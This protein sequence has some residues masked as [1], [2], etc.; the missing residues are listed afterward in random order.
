[1]L[2]VLVLFGS[3]HAQAQLYQKDKSYRLTILHTN[4]HHGRFWKNDNG[5]YGMAAR[6]TLIDRIRAEVKQ[7][8]G[9]LLLL[10]GGDIN[11]GVPQSD[12]L[13]AEPDFKG[14]KLLGYNAMSLGNHEFDQ[15]PDVLEQ[16][17]KWAGFPFLSANIFKTGTSEHA[18]QSYQVF[19]LDGL[20]VVV[21]G[22]TTKDTTLIANPANTGHLHFRPA[23]EVAK[24]LM[25]NLRRQ[26]AI[27]IAV[28]HL[29]HYA[30]G[31]HGGNIPG[32]VTLARSV[33]GFDVIVGGHT[34][35]PLPLP[36]R[37]NDTLILQAHEWG[38]YVGRL[39]LEFFNG[40]LTM[41]NY[42]LIPVN[43][44]QRL[45]GDAQADYSFIDKEIIEDQT[46]LDLLKPY[47][48]KGK[49]Q[50]SLVIG[51]VDT[52]FNGDREIVRSQE[53]NLGNLVAEAQ[54]IKVKAHL[55]IINS[56]GIRDSLQAGAITYRD[57]LMVQPF[58]TSI[59]YITFSG[60]EL[61]KYLQEIG[62]IKKGTGG[63]PQISGVKVVFSGENL[64]EVWVQ[65]KKISAIEKYKLAIP[66]FL[67][68][69]GD[70]YPILKG[71]TLLVDSGFIDA[72][73]LLEY[74]VKNTPIKS[75]DFAPQG[76]NV[77]NRVPH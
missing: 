40:R 32:D 60:L 55:S 59:S 71:H 13:N 44:R 77:R 25:P 76:D 31:N 64:Q 22:F 29:G 9:H 53:T 23:V 39:D 8:G 19:D 65:G 73:A 52:K 33:P 37:Q 27:V 63:Y 48:D 54:R 26:G 74:I 70:G 35:I 61:R 56:G 20:K 45:Q 68:A 51:Q 62:K 46:M 47:H 14:M 38:K 50:L 5:E 69:G 41:K 36:D 58:G 11:T 4:D 16:Q 3:G 2:L 7:M 57:I 10:S 28:T 30:N 21:V 49:A 42:R 75:V 1:M 34:Q 66:S 24:K 72:D 67:A 6:K 12:L 15:P 17:S 18:F 43:L